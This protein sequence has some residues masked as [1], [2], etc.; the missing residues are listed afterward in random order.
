MDPN[1]TLELWRNS[2]D[3]GEAKQARNDLA[4]W[5]NNGGFWPSGMSPFELG[6]MWRNHKLKPPEGY[7]GFSAYD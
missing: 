6:Y 2:D 4:T 1:A 5:L 7:Q 3:A